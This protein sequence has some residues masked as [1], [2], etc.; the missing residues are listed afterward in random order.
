VHRL[1][2]IVDIIGVTTLLELYIWRWQYSAPRAWIAILGWMAAS[3]L[4]HRD[5]PRTLGWGIDNLA[6]AT[7]RAAIV[8]GLFAAVLIVIGVARR[9]VAQ[10][11]ANHGSI[12]HLARYFA[13]C[14]FQQA[15][16]NSLVTNRLLEIS[17]RPWLAA[18]IAGT[19]FAAMHWPNP[20]LV[21]LTLVGGTAMAWLFARERNILPLALGQVMLSLLIWWAFPLSWHHGLRVGPGYYFFP[22]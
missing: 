9:G 14:I 5:T 2:S 15:V 21:P 12:T 17:A 1:K 20:V 18:V 11:P 19:I 6:A 13:F 7:R 10:I 4:I 3:F 8:L 22:R 16:L